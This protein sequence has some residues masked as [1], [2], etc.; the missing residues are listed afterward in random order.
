MAAQPEDRGP[1]LSRRP[2]QRRAAAPSGGL[3]Q[4]GGPG[5]RR[6]HRLRHGHRQARCPL[7][8][9][10]RPAWQH[11]G[12]LPGDGP[13][14]TR[15]AARRDPAALRHGGCGA[16]AAIHGRERLAA[17]GE[18]GRALRSSTPCWDS[19]RRWAAGARRCS[20]ISA[21][22]WPSPAAIATAASRRPN[23]GRHGRRPEG[24][25][26]GL[27]H[28]PAFRRRPSRRCA[29]RHRDREDRALRP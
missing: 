5:P 29:A 22:R 25:L 9:P 14:R 10:S 13:R 23:L 21:K 11:R 3:P 4:S 12:L 26:G 6:H 27:A 19:A 20:P 15:R 16:A 1:A 28:R 7:R 8:R 24:A 18:A 2:R 17:R